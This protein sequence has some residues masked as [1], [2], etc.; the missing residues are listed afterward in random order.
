MDQYLQSLHE[1]LCSWLGNS[2]QI[3]DEVSFGHAN[4]SVDKGKGALMFVGD[5]VYLEVLS[6]VQ[7]GGLC[8]AFISDFIKSLGEEEKTTTN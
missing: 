2:T 6:T 7:F 3:V 5:D 4:A 1:G 8:Q